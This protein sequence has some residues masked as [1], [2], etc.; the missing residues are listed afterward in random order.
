VSEG[1]AG[2]VCRSLHAARETDVLPACFPSASRK[3]PPRPGA[4]D[5]GPVQPVPGLRCSDRARTSPPRHEAENRCP[6]GRLLG[7]SPCHSR[8]RCSHFAPCSGSHPP[9][10]RLDDCT[11]PPRSNSVGTRK[12]LRSRQRNTEHFSRGANVPP[13]SLSRARRGRECSTNQGGS[14]RPAGG[15]PIRARVPCNTTPFHRASGRSI[16]NRGDR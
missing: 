2:G 8:I 1:R 7:P 4:L 15:S 9:R 16:S 12:T 10:A 14:A 11:R 5:S 3:W 13:A 6:W